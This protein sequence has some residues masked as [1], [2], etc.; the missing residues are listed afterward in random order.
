MAGK[1]CAQVL[2]HL[3]VS[4][5]HDAEQVVDGA[6]GDQSSVCEASGLQHH[7]AKATQHAHGF[8]AEQQFAA[9]ERQGQAQ[10]QVQCGVRLSGA[11]LGLHDEA[12]GLVQGAQQGALETGKTRTQ[13]Q[14]RAVAL[15]TFEAGPQ[16]RRE[17]NGG[18]Q[19][20]GGARGGFGFRIGQG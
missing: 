12:A 16:S 2:G 3:F 8:A 13:N 4:P 15:Q 11:Y 5:R 17:R 1:L 19:F 6:V 20:P 10:V 14:G 7:M 18:Q 9:V